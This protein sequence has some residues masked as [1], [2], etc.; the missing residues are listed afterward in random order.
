MCFTFKESRLVEDWYEFYRDDFDD[1]ILEPEWLMFGTNAGRSITELGEVCTIA[2]TDGTHAG[3]WCGLENDA[4]RM[5]FELEANLPCRITTKLNEHTINPTWSHAGIMVARNPTATAALPT[6]AM[7]YFWGRFG[8][9]NAIWASHNCGTPVGAGLVGAPW[10][11]DGP[12]WLRVTISAANLLSFEASIDGIAWTTLGWTVTYNYDP[13]YVGLVCANFDT[14]PSPWPARAAPFEYF[15]IEEFKA[16]HP[17]FERCYAPIDTRAP[18]TFYEGRIKRMSSLKRAV[19]D[20]TGL[21]Q[22]SD[23]N[24]KLANTDKQFSQLMASNV[25]KNQEVTLHHAWTEEHE[26]LKEHIITMIVEDH[27]MRGPDFDIKLKDITQKYFTRKVPENICTIDEFPDIHSDYEGWYMPEILGNASLP[28][29]YEHPGAVQAVYTDIVSDRCLAAAGWL[30]GITEVFV[31]DV[32][33]GFSVPAIAAD[34]HTY[35]D[36]DADPGDNPTITFNCEGYSLAAWDSTNNYIQN[37]A[38]IIQYYLR[39][40]MGIPASLVDA[41][42]FATL[43]TYYVSEG[44]SENFYLIIQDQ[45]D[46]M[47]VLRELL[48]TGGAKGFVAKGGK[49]EVARKNFCN[50]QITPAGPAHIFEQIELFGPPHR[51]WNLTSAVNTVKGQFGLIPWQS[52]FTGIKEEYRENDY[53]SPLEDNIRWKEPIKRMI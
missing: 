50:W 13:L 21:F 46:G 1:G 48:F 18:E 3:W 4:P 12:Y 7:S 22:I 17:T 2:I 33:V 6:P 14:A 45:V 41:P 37:L 34:G 39:Y 24:I 16:Q 23:M 25:L 8:G 20:K 32:S 47:E 10:N 15:F 36:L 51:Q 27:S 26:H 19:D 49:F 53:E 5:Y 30:N 40:I 31:D 42:S 28:D 43:A 29:T 38:R 35:I 44:V 9:L 52:L 11:G